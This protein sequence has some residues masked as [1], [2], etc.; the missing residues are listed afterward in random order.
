[1]KPLLSAAVF[2]LTL[3]ASGCVSI[4]PDAAAFRRDAVAVA[5]FDAELGLRPAY[6]LIVANTVRCHEGD[7]SQMSSVGDLHFSFPVGSK[8]IEGNFDPG[9]G[10]ADVAVRF[11]N[12]THHGMLQVIDLV[13]VSDTQTRVAVHRL[14]DSRKWQTATES[15]EGWFSGGEDCYEML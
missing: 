1:M 12:L 13:R 8:R 3:A 10:R 7:A 11:D 14:N 5:S 15:V 2:G 6:E 9:A 4:P